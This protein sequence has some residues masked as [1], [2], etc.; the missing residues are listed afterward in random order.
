MPKARIPMNKIRGIVRLKESKFSNRMISRALGVSRPAVGTYLE[1]IE[2]SQTTWEEVQ[3]LTDDQLIERLK[4]STHEPEDPRSSEFLKLLPEIC[5]ELGEK[6]TTRQGLWEEYMQNNPNGYSYTQFC[7]HIQQ[8]LSD[9][10]LSMHLHHEPGRK[11]FVDY[12]GDPPSLYDEKTGLPRK[13]ELFVSN[14]PASGLI[15]AEAMESQSLEDFIQGTEHSFGYAG[16]VPKII[17]PDNLK[18]AVTKADPYEPLI[19]Q[20]YEDFGHYYG[21]VVIPARPRKPKDKAL[22]E[23]AVHLVYTRI[24]APLRNRRFSTLD[25]LNTAI[26]E[27]LDAANDRNM[28]KFNFSRR[29]RFEELEAP[30]LAP[31]P[32]RR[33]VIRRFVT[34]ITVQINYHV[35]FSL[36]KHYYSVPYQYRKKDVRLSYTKDEIEIYHKHIRIAAHHRDR[37]AHQYTTIPSHMPSGHRILA[38]WT[39]ER[40]LQWAATIGAELTQVISAVIESREVPEQAFKSCLGILNLEKKFGKQRLESASKRANRYQLASYKALKNILD[41]GLDQKQEPDEQQPQ[42]VA[43]VHPNIRGAGYYAKTGAAHE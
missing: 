6:Y 9:S 28:K 25:T 22:C 11:L 12:A 10:E 35:Y 5:K 4:Q 30:H 14:F 23:A 15:Y 38:E 1:Q 13:V 40:F 34:N 16:G 24:L 33:Y 36:D 8:Y 39:P 17:T 7:Y 18:A 31:L 37:R 32:A 3:E 43:T 26:W 2:A 41:R 29:E 42:A 20:T 19:N 27:L 21:C